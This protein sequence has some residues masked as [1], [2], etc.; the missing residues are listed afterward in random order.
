MKRAL[1]AGA[2]I[3]TFGLAQATII[4]DAPFNSHMVL[5]ARAHLTISGRSTL[6]EEQNITFTKSW[7]SVT[8]TF[9]TRK[10]GRFSFRVFTPPA[11][12]PYLFHFTDADG[13]LTLW[14]VAFGKVI[15][16]MGQSNAEMPLYAPPSGYPE[17]PGALNEINSVNLPNLRYARIS[18]NPSETPITSLTTYWYGAT[19]PSVGALSAIGYFTGKA[20]HLET[21]VPVGIIQVARGGS[22][23]EEWM[24]RNLIA[25][26]PGGPAEL[27]EE[28]SS[29][30]GQVYNAG[31]FPLRNFKV[32][33][34]IWYQGEAN[35]QYAD[36]YED[37]LKAFLDMTQRM[38]HIRGK[39]LVQ[40]VVEITPLT[41]ADA[42]GRPWI[43]AIQNRVADTPTTTMV[44]SADLTPEITSPHPVSKQALGTRIASF[45]EVAFGQGANPVRPRL[46]SPS[47]QPD[48]SVLL[49]VFG[50]A[51]PYHL[52]ANNGFSLVNQAGMPIA[53]TAVM[54]G[55]NVRVS[56]F[57]VVNPTGV[58][59]MWSAAGQPTLF[60]AAGLPVGVYASDR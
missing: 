8:K 28:A 15:L 48:G 2:G 40:Q 49:P 5:P 38:F 23:I 59:Y 53:A 56:N 55:N 60:D 27:N 43:R 3:A 31:L 9:R 30:Y 35:A 47:W 32:D 16:V 19:S 25:T 51:P 12:G 42:N 22:R 14:N 39:H 10:D 13:T 29:S 1:L 54:E 11:G 58:R 4:L 33:G 7:N 46:G 41:T 21:G 24:P 20:L 37:R 26:L 45:F 18:S 52:T 50:G 17:I 34:L 6:A 36:T 57:S 44:P